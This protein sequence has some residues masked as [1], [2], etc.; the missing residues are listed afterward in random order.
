MVA[1]VVGAMFCAFTPSARADGQTAQ[2]QTESPEMR[3][4]RALKPT[5]IVEIT[6]A[7]VN[8]YLQDDPKEFDIPDGFE[9]PQVVFGNGYVEVSA[10]TQLLF[11]PVRVRVLMAPEIVGGRL[12]LAVRKV[13]A[14]KI[15][16]PSSFHRGVGDMITGVINQAL[17]QN[18]VM[19][20]KT[21][22]TNGLV[23]ATAVVNP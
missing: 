18:N 1:V 21:E 17:D 23:R 15:R 22:V 6:Q 2:V 12:R 14:G 4:F 9:D 8:A 20:R 13:H 10:R 16:I 7:N 3:L 11:T 5:L 19:L